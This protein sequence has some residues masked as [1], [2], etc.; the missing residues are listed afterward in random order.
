MAKKNFV[1]GIDIL[2]Q[3][4][5]PEFKKEQNAIDEKNKVEQTRTTLIVNTGTYEKIRA[6]AYWERKSI[7]DI[8]EKSF[9]LT[10]IQYSSEEL[11]EMVE[12]YRKS[13][14]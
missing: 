1:S 2:F 5:K 4:P 3:S 6:V 14:T 13:N 7:K 8:I 11:K 12:H 10:L 9:N